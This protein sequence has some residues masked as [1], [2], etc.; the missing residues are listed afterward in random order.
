MVSLQYPDR[1]LH[2][3]NSWLYQKIW[4]R[5]F[6]RNGQFSLVICGRCGSGKSYLA[7]E[8]I[9]NLFG[10]DW[11]VKRFTCFSAEQFADIVRQDLPKGTAILFDDSGLAALSG[12]SLTTEVK[13]LSKI[14]QSVRSRNFIIIMTLPSLFLLSTSVRSQIDFYCEPLWIDFEKSI[15]HAK[16]QSLSTNPK[17]GKLYSA[18]PIRFLKK[19]SPI[20]GIEV[21]EKQKIVSI[22]F[23]KPPIE[24]TTPYEAV[25]KERVMAFNQEAFEKIVRKRQKETGVG[26]RKLSDIQLLNKIRRNRDSFVSNGRVDRELLCRGLGV[27]VLKAKQLA[28][29][30]NN[31]D[32]SDSE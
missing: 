17:S 15:C 22:P 19:V 26:K 25:K 27:G 30:V 6:L 2:C 1:I 32:L 20:T 12:D 16:F 9:H 8:I 3:Q 18:N 5:I 7:L 29:I 11:D 23:A 31:K 24:L 13:Q 21:F 4:K 10:L 14:F 28:S